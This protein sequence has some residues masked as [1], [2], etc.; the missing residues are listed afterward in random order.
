[1]MY[2]SSQD[3]IGYGLGKLGGT[4]GVFSADKV[5]TP[6]GSDGRDQI[7]ESRRYWNVGRFDLMQ[8]HN[9]VDWEEH[10]PMLFEMKQAGEIRYVGITTSE[11]R[12]HGEFEEIM[13]DQPLDFIQASYNIRN[14]ELE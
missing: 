11:G 1:P 10:L 13:R 2:G 14:R 12:R 7:E 4:S 5:W 3:V 8:V 9:I 6:F